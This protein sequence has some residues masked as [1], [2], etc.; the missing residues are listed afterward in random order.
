MTNSVRLALVL[1]NHQ[2]IGN[3]DHVFEQAYQDSYLPFLHVFE[4]F[5]SL[6][7]SLHTS[8]S[9][10]EWLEAHHPE[11]LDR[12]AALVAAGRV[13]II[14]GAFYEPILAMLPSRDRI[15]QIRSYTGWLERRLGATVSGMWIPERVWEQSMTRDIA[16]AGIEYAVLDDYHFKNAGLTENQLHGYYVTEDDGRVLRIFPGSEQLR[17]LI[18]FQDPEHTIGYLGQV[19]AEQPNALVVFGDDGEK[20]GTWPDTKKHVYEDGWLQRFFEQLAA[21]ADWLKTVTLAEARAELAP[22]GKVFVPEGSYREMTEW[23]LPAS[24]IVEFENVQHELEHQGQWPLVAPFVR[25]GFWRNFKAKYPETDEMYARMM[26]VSRRLA[27]LQATGAVSEDL[28]AARDELYRGQCNCS[29]WHG[30]FG[31]IYLPHLRN[32]IYRHL[33]AADNLLDR[34]AGQTGSRVLADAEDF[35]FDG[36]PEI[37]LSSDRLVA[38]FDPSRGGRLYELDVRAI[39]HNLL[40][41]LAR[42]EEAYHTK[43]RGGGHQGDDDCASI[44]DRVVFK[45]EGLDEMLHYDRDLRKSLQDHFFDNDVSLAEVANA[46]AEEL[47]DFASGRFEARMR[48]HDDRVEAQ[49]TRRGVACGL[50]VT[51]TKTVTLAAGSSTLDVQYQLEGLPTDRLL[52]FAVEFGFAGLPAEADDRYFYDRDRQRL[53]QLGRQIDMADQTGLGLIDEWLGVDIG[54]SIARPSNIWTF[55]IQS[56]SQSEGGFEAV[57][58]SVVVM[59]HW[60]VQGDEE[61]RWSVSMSLSIDTSLAENRRRQAELAT[62][63]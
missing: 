22:L 47:G 39:K 30:A 37:R 26:M 8:G 4:P 13:E 42:R 34:V 38:L 57:H 12:L 35:N 48:R 11:Y 27:D 2:P 31:G 51:L 29:Y 24:R 28:D 6:R 3:F 53:G 44:H 7:I 40:A 10:I 14:G 21:N 25:G 63:G 56:V 19:A 32:A 18:P 46:T 49:F 58:Q 16:D 41:T 9:L 54:L 50:P 36:E 5:S 52:H 33:I 61:G 45:Q 1:H 15:G 55:P 23:A 60:L 59:P 62:V 20:F 17:Y 43:I